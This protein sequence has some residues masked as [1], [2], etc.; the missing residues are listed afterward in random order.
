MDFEAL[1]LSLDIHS[2]FADLMAFQSL[3]KCHRGA[4]NRGLCEAFSIISAGSFSS[5]EQHS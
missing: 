2:V 3:P 1:V 5:C 4:H